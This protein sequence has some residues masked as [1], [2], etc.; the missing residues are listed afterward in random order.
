MPNP[1]PFVPPRIE[2]DGLESYLNATKDEHGGA[3]YNEFVKRLSLSEPKTV[4]GR[5]FKVT[6]STIR[7]W[8]LIYERELAKKVQQHGK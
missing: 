6:A 8:K 2:D 5:A 3:D 1:R 4:I 7:Y